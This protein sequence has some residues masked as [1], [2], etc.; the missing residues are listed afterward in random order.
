MPLLTREPLES[1]LLGA[2]SISRLRSSDLCPNK[3]PSTT[4]MGIINLDD[5]QGLTDLHRSKY[6]CRC[7]SVRRSIRAEVGIVPDGQG[8]TCRYGK[9]GCW[10][11]S[12]WGTCR[13]GGFVFI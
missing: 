11:Y 8:C 4:G 9:G 10:A 12:L 13:P 6:G 5:L 3:P 7:A 2:D 1:V